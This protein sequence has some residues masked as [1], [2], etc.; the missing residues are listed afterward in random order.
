M[1]L[2][3]TSLAYYNGTGADRVLAIVNPVMSGKVVRLLGINVYSPANL[4]EFEIE[5][6]DGIP[7]DSGGAASAPVYKTDSAQAGEAVLV[8]TDPAFDFTGLTCT[9]KNDLSTYLSD[10]GD[11]TTLLFYVPDSCKPVLNAGEAIT[12]RL[13]SGVADYEFN[14]YWEET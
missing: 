4:S 10:A 3:F 9:W 13:P 2:T 5:R 7:V 1:S 12:V 8:K 11:D 6:W 14:I